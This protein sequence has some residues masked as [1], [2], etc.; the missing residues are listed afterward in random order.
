MIGALSPF[1]GKQGGSSET[2]YSSVHKKIFTLPNDCT[3]YP[4][5]DYKVSSNRVI[6]SRR[7]KVPS[8]V[9]HPSMTVSHLCLLYLRSGATQQHYRGG[10]EIQPS[11]NQASGRIQRDHG[12]SKSFLSEE[13]RRGC[14]SEHGVRRLRRIVGLKTLRHPPLSVHLPLPLSVQ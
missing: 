10:E 8:C 7:S 2:L 13:D 1:L 5:H 11:S 6:S 9:V 12:E 4:A 14:A 3:V